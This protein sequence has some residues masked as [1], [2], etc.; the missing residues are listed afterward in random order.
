MP[1]CLE[2]VQQADELRRRWTGICSAFVANAHLAGINA[3]DIFIS[4]TPVRLDIGAWCSVILAEG[5]GEPMAVVRSTV[6]RPMTLTVGLGTDVD[7]AADLGEAVAVALRRR[8]RALDRDQIAIEEEL[9]YMAASTGWV[10]VG[11]RGP[12]LA[13]AFRD[14]LDRIRGRIERSDAKDGDPALARFSVAVELAG[15]TYAQAL[16]VLTGLRGVWARVAQLPVRDEEFEISG[17][18]PWDC[19]APRYQQP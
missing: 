2:S 9:R 7:V 17:A 4:G 3:S 19:R 12:A 11:R 1:A 13:A 18:P 6:A 5:P 8:L 10:S 16:R 15:L 14:D